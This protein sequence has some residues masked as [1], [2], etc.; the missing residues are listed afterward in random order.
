MKTTMKNMFQPHMIWRQWSPKRSSRKT[1]PNPFLH[2]RSPAESPAA[3]SLDSRFHDIDTK[4]TDAVEVP[5]MPILRSLLQARHGSWSS[6]SSR[7]NN[8]INHNHSARL[9]T[10][11]FRK[12]GGVRF[13]ERRNQ[14]YETER[15]TN[16]ESLRYWYTDSEVEQMMMH[17]CQNYGE[18]DQ[19]DGESP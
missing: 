16:E 19:T 9:L 13:N 15:M 17:Y 5:E 11:P 8:S 12:R 18:F 10:N 4:P 14:Y 1:S 3:A 2:G 7:S 6:S